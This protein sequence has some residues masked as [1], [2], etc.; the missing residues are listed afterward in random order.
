MQRARRAARILSASYEQAFGDLDLKAGQF[1]TL[2]AISVG[3]RASVSVLAQ[4]LGM[5]RTTLS[6]AL[7]PLER[8]GLVELTRSE[9]DSRVTLVSL[10][11]PGKRLL[12]RAITR[13]EQAQAQAEAQ[14]GEDELEIVSR[15]LDRL[16]ATP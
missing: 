2:V 4:H 3:E 16:G 9:D 13:W 12:R 8:R 6:R 5:D 15:G 14:L 1:S 7:R 11:G 10:T